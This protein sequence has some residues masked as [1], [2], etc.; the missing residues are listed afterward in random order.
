MKTTRQINSQIKKEVIKLMG[1]GQESYSKKTTRDDE[2]CLEQDI[3]IKYES[4][5]QI[6]VIV[7]YKLKAIFN[8]DYNKV[9]LI[10]L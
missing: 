3:T 9:E 5:C 1:K 2:F 10:Q 4:T 8:K 7:D 6:G